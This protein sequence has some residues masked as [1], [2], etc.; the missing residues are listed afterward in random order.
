MESLRA[1]GQ[2]KDYKPSQCLQPSHHSV[3]LC[4]IPMFSL[5]ARPPLYRLPWTVWHLTLCLF[6]LQLSVESPAPPLHLFCAE[7]IPKREDEMKCTEQPNKE[8]TRK[9]LL[10]TVVIEKNSMNYEKWGYTYLTADLFHVSIHEK[11][12]GNLL[13]GPLK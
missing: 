6:T 4:Y 8:E 5:W 2:G 9:A 12:L 11:E 10:L 1:T 7:W 13:R 3:L